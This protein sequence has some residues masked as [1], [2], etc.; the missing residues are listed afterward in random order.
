[1][2]HTRSH[3]LVSAEFS[4]LEAKSVKEHSRH[5]REVLTNSAVAGDEQKSLLQ[6]RLVG[7]QE[8]AV[9]PTMTMIGAQNDR[10]LKRNRLLDET[11]RRNFEFG[12]LNRVIASPSIVVSHAHVH[13]SAEEPAVWNWISST[14]IVV[15]SFLREN[16]IAEMIFD[17]AQAREG[18]FAELVLEKSHE[19][20]VVYFILHGFEL[21]G[22]IW[23]DWNRNWFTVRC[24]DCYC[25]PL[26]IFW[27]HS[28]HWTHFPISSFTERFSFFLNL[29][30]EE[31]WLVS[32]K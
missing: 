16:D 15:E 8:P 20:Q 11:A 26:R 24:V 30:T 14:L 9:P 18:F 5:R 25:F 13:Q 19:V 28:S 23:C 3:S 2:E 17:G 4:V 27:T 12:H 7:F 1:V 29:I 22:Y 21:F 32:E 6:N 10:F 31:T